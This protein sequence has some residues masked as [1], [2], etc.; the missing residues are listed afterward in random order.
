MTPWRNWSVRGWCAND[1]EYYD[2]TPNTAYI[3]YFHSVSEPGDN[4]QPL[5]IQIIGKISKQST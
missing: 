3:D 4:F 2:S 1:M 5:S